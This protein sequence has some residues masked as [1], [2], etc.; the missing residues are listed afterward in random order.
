MKNQINI[1]FHSYFKMVTSVSSSGVSFKVALLF[2]SLIVFRIEC[3]LVDWSALGVPLT[4]T[5]S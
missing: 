1:I 2:A 3:M 4:L 5:A